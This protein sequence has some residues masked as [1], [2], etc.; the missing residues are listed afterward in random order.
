VIHAYVAG[1]RLSWVAVED[2]A[3]VAALA[4]AHPEL[5][6][7]Q[8]Y[9]LGYDALTFRELADLMTSIIGKP[10]RYEPLA[11]EV[12]L[13]AMKSAGAE[14]AYMTCVYEHYKRYAA[15]TIPGADDTFDNF[16]QLTGKPPTQW[17]GFIEKHKAQF[18]Y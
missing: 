3:Q 11:P 6:A 2:V 10:F 5:H 16:P 7:G 18:D 9:R 1:A 12:F 8:T 15:G 13:E 4:L 14:M 17:A